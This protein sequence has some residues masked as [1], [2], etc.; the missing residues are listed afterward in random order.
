MA[1]TKPFIAVDVIPGYPFADQLNSCIAL[2]KYVQGQLI[3]QWRVDIRVGSNRIVLYEAIKAINTFESI[4]CLAA[5]G[6][7]PQAEMLSRPLYE[8][9][10]VASWASHHPEDARWR[11]DLNERYLQWLHFVNRQEAGIYRDSGE[12]A[13]LTDEER[14]KARQ[15]FGQYGEKSWTG[16]TIRGLAIEFNELIEHA[17]S[18]KQFDAILNS[19][20]KFV[21][22]SIHSSG[23]GSW[24]LVSPGD[25]A[26]GED[27]NNSYVTLGPSE[28]AIR[29]ALT[30]G[31][32][33]F[34]MMLQ[35]YHNHFGEVFGPDLSRLIYEVWVSFLNSETRASLGRNSPCPCR[36]GA[37]FKNCHQLMRGR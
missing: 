34:T 5:G 26:L 23:L 9:A 20:N 2:L 17:P 32:N 11:Y 4:L 29:D 6:F 10:L 7:G 14:A 25:P 24:H 8:S 36:S 37:K 22:W 12:P 19:T 3:A 15:L 33:M 35:I 1:D 21:N 27:A 31:W 18:R 30:L 28:V 13:L 16:T